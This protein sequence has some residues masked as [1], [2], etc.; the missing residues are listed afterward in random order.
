MYNK[1]LKMPKAPSN[2]KGHAYIQRQIY[3]YKD[4]ILPYNCRKNPESIKYL[5]TSEL[6]YFESYKKEGLTEESITIWVNEDR[7][8]NTTGN[9]HTYW[10]PYSYTYFTPYDLYMRDDT[11]YFDEYIYFIDVMISDE[12]YQQMSIERSK[13]IFEELVSKV[14]HPNRVSKWIELAYD[15]TLL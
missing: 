12:E 11:R 13:I 8:S 1:Y 6:L 10:T 15:I 5:D 2:Y 14:F 9:I 7:V 3:Y 4:Y